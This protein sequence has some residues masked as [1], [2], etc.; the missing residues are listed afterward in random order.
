M[1][2]FDAVQGALD[3]YIA[4]LATKLSASNIIKALSGGMMSA[5]PVTLG[6]ALLAIAVNLPIPG[7]TEWLAA[8]GL[9]AVV[10]QVLAVSMNML[11]LYMVFAMSYRWGKSLELPGMT[12][13]IVTIGMF[14]VLMPLVVET[15][16]YSVTYLIN[17]SYLGSNGIFLGIILSILVPK[18]LQLLMKHLRLKLPDSVPPMVTDS[19]SPTFAAIVMFTVACL[20]KWGIMFTPWGNLFD[21]INTLVATP[22]MNVGSS[23]LAI[24]LVYTFASLLWFFGVHPSAI[25]NVYAPVISAITMANI[26]ALLSGQPLPHL[27]W[28]VINLVMSIG[29]TGE[30]IGVALSALTAKSERYKAISR[31]AIVPAIFNISEPLMFGIPVVLNPTFFIPIVL[32]TPVCGAIAWGLSELGLGAA[33]SPAVNVPWIMPQPITGFL[34]GG[35]GVCAIIVVCIIAA[36]L[37]FFPFFKMADR[38]ALADERA[39]TTEEA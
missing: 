30:G 36:T 9:S 24:I 7:W 19:L 18:V 21:L 10:N 35:I 11:A 23:P 20:I 16:D 5:M 14:L 32:A 12:A 1:A 22:I 39:A 13:A 29:G 4:P 37:V 25:L 28:Q 8:S 3:R 33:L 2:V 31:L 26:E 6:V 38:M 15:S 27:T 17:T 34:A